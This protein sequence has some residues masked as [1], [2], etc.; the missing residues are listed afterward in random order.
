VGGDSVK[1]AS[2]PDKSLVDVVSGEKHTHHS[3]APPQVPEHHRRYRITI[4]DG[5]DRL[6]AVASVIPQNTGNFWSS[7]SGPFC[8]L[9]VNS[10]LQ[11]AAR[12]IC[13]GNRC[14]PPG[15][16]PHQGVC[17]STL[18][19]DRQDTH[20]STDTTSQHSAGSTSVEIPTMVHHTSANVGG[21]PQSDNSNRNNGEQGQLRTALTTS[22]MAHL[23]E[24]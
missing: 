19:S 24:R 7:E 21:L 5:Q 9:S 10:V 8:D 6:E 1:R 3:S 12:S 11:L 16:D 13:R 23:R 17:Q 4:P 14:I 22:R 2:Q 18:E 20:S 15:V